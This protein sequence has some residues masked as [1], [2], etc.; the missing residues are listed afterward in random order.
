VAHRICLSGGIIARPCS[1]DTWFRL[2]HPRS[3]KTFTGDAKARGIAQE[4]AEPTARAKSFPSTGNMTLRKCAF[5]E[6][7]AI[8]DLLGP[9][10]GNR[11]T[12]NEQMR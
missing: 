1:K 5:E 10:P 2:E 8:E 4:F 3:F 9:R 7:E 12:S 11:L 6:F